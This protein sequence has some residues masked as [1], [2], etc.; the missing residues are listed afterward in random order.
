MTESQEKSNELINL[1]EHLPTIKI[2]LTKEESEKKPLVRV[3]L[4]NATTY[5]LIGILIGGIV[6]GYAQW[7]SNLAERNTQIILESLKE[8][9]DYN[10]LIDSLNKLSLLQKTGL[11]S[12]KI[13]YDKFKEFVPETIATNLV[14]A[15]Q[16]EVLG[17]Q[18]LLD[19][20]LGQAQDY[21]NK[22]YQAYPTYHNVDE[23][24]Q[25]LLKKKTSVSD[26]GKE[27]YCPIVDQ[28][29]WGMPPDLKQQ[30]N[31]KGNCKK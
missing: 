21:F 11:L 25:K 7:Q 6:T 10:G 3:I 9:N 18:A 29:S 1:I 30:M 17:F 4:E 28:Y 14:T 19:Q 13:D 8:S 16:Y 22:S 24:S 2:Y 20:K 12:S 31:Q 27:I 15:T 23:I 26:W 5:G